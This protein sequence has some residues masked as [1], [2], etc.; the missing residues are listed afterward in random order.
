MTA[1]ESEKGAKDWTSVNGKK[2]W[3]W[4]MLSQNSFREDRGYGSLKSL[5]PVRVGLTLLQASAAWGA[6]AGGSPAPMRS[7][8]AG[9]IFTFL[10]LTLGPIKI[11][12][13]FAKVTQGADLWLARRM[14]LR[15]IL[16][17]I[18]ALLLAAAIG[19]S[20]LRRDDMPVPVLALAAGIVLFLVAL[21]GI[22]HQFT[23]PA[24][25]EGPASAP[26][27]SMAV[28]PIAFPTIVTPYGIAAL[29]IFIT[30]SSNWQGKLAIGV[31]L[32]GIML[33][34]LIAMLLARHILRLLGVFLQILG[35]VLGIIQVALGL[36]IILTSLQKLWT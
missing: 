15:A 33:L 19:E 11:I 22:L 4:K 5:W 28:T 8:S 18:L 7:F 2:D 27:L 6:Q 14:A 23:P 16:F 36:Q 3:W 31:I 1:E 29:I 26:T 34:D 20:F 25:S 9:Q 30:I 32:L 10:F 12:G 13:P 17:S 35:A 21:Q 24:R